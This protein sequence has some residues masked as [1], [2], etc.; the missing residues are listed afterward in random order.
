T[1]G[2]L[3]QGL[4]GRTRRRP[5]LS[6]TLHP[7]RGHHQLTPARPRS[8]RPHPH[9]HLQGL[10]RCRPQ[11][12]PDPDRRRV[13]PPFA[14]PSAPPGLHQNPPLRL[15]R[16]QSPPSARAPGPSRSGFLAAALCPR[17]N[18]TPR[19]APAHLPPLP[20]HRGALH[21]TRRTLRQS[22][23]LCPP[24]ALRAGS[25]LHR[26]FMSPRPSNSKSGPPA[27]AVPPHSPNG[28]AQALSPGALA[29]SGRLQR[30]H[31]SR[32]TAGSSHSDRPTTPYAGRH[33]LGKSNHLLLL[34]L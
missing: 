34:L 19:S 16:Q 29:R 18:P 8:P 31:V 25:R 13:P 6:G 33:H 30:A 22:Q 7:P 26:H 15:A 27:T 14:P 3:R 9:L 10:R 1:L 24:L 12:S 2:R 20:G 21:R 17:T 23:P 32:P 5:G 4:R 28:H 11:Q